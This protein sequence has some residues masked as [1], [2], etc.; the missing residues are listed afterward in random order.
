MAKFEVLNK[1][2]SR[3]EFLATMGFG[4]MTVMGVSSIVA[5]LNGKHS[6]SASSGYGSSTYG[7]GNST[8][9]AKALSSPAK[10]S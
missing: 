1:K 8:N 9:P 2:V 10:S 6:G 5:L 7:G 3:K 4:A